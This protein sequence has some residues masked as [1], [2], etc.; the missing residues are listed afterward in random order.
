[1][2]AILNTTA[3]DPK[4]RFI[5]PTLMGLLCGAI[6]LLALLYHASA[7]SANILC[8]KPGGG[9]GCYASIT[10]ALGSAQADDT[11]RVAMGTY[12]ESL[13]ITQTVA[14]EG[15]WNLDFSQRN[16]DL[17]VTT[18]RPSDPS[19]A[20]IVIT[21]QFADW[22][23]VAP[24]IDGFTIT[25]A[26]SNNH[27]GGVRMT[28]SNAIIS[29]N[30]ITDNTAYLYGG[31]VWVQRGAPLF[32]T[33]H[34]ENNLVDGYGGGIE[35]ESTQATLTGNIITS[36]VVTAQV[37]YGGGIA[38]EGGGPV[39]LTGNTIASNVVTAT[40]GYGGGI[41]VQQGGPIALS[42]NTVN[43][44]SIVYPSSLH[45]P[46]KAGSPS[47]A[48]RGPSRTIGSLDPNGNAGGAGGGVSLQYV[49]AT[50]SSNII[51]DN[52][53]A[54]RYN[55]Y[56]GGT[57]IYSATV[58]LD[59]NTIQS[60]TSTL[61]ASG[62]A[63]GYGG[64]S[65]ALLGTTTF[66][67]DTVQNNNT[68]ANNVRG[69]GGGLFAEQAQVNLDAVRITSNHA[70]LEGGLAFLGALVD[71]SPA[72]TMTNSLVAN[73]SATTYGGVTADSVAPGT[74]A[75]DTVINNG[76]LGIYTESPLTITNSII[77]SHTLGIN[78]SH[79]ITETYND[80]YANT[81]N[82]Q[83]FTLDPTDLTVNPQLTSNYHLSA[84]SPVMDAGTRN[85]AP[86]DDIDGE[87]RPMKGTSGLYKVDIGADE[88]TGPAQTN[89]HL[90]T[91]PADF[92]LI[93]PGNPT[94]NPNSD[95]SNDWI[96]YSV[97]GGDVNGDNK[98]DLFAGA[99]NLSDDFDGG[100]ND[101]GRTFGL[102]GN[103]TR[104]LG[105]TDLLTTTP[106][107]EVRSWIHQQHTSQALAAA[108]LNGDG[109]SDLIIGS[110]GGD[111]NGTPVTGTV[112][113]F[114]G[115]PGLS[116]TRTLS[117]TMQANWRFKSGE[118]TQTFA[119]KNALAAGQ[120]N[121]TG[122]DDLAMGEAKATGPGNRTHAGAIYVFFGSNNLPP[123]WDLGTTPASL[124]IYGPANEA[125]LGKVA[126]GDV[127]GDGK[128]DLIARS[129]S[130]IYVFYGPLPSGVID[131]AT[132]PADA[133]ITNADDGWLAAGDVNGDGKADIV[134]S[135]P[136]EAD[137]VLGGNLPSTQTL[138]QAAWAT[139]TGVNA[140]SLW[141]ADWNADGK[142]E[143]LVGDPL[144]NRTFVIFGG[145][146]L[147][148]T[149]DIYERA[150]WIIY[151]ESL[152]DQFGHSLGSADL[153]GDGVTD[154]ILGSRIH[155][156]DDHPNH[157]AD[158][159]AVYVLYGT[160][161]QPGG[162][163]TPTPGTPSPTR[164]QGG[165]TLTTTPGGP[166]ATPGGPTL[167]TTPVI[168]NISFSDVPVGSTFYPYIHC[169]ACL[170]II[171][172]YPD[173]S[174]KPNNDVTRGQLAKIVSNSAGFS[175]NQTTR[176]FQDVAS[177]ST[178]FQYIGRLASRGY[179]SGY[180]CGAGEPCVPPD[181]LPYF[182]PNNNAT[183]GQI[184]K[185]VSNAAG[186]NDPP[187]NQIFQDVAPGST[188]YDYVQRLASRGYISGYR[189]GG[190]VPPGSE[191][192]IPPGNRPYFR[193][194]NNATRGQT[195][196]IVSNTFFP[197]CQAHGIVKPGG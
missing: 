38:V 96:G 191:P 121:G 73:N 72:Y 153:D 117:P 91:Q 168:C 92:T 7:A 122:P 60:N 187:G 9:D 34:I 44:N 140:G 145:I 21:G 10:A 180:P 176:T 151:G 177:G 55:G 61:D 119:G 166:T 20:V 136:T 110:Q 133:T 1:M 65:Y 143:V 120:L 5:V 25:G 115:G 157:F 105:V 102:Y 28:D 167:T 118:S 39:T 31:G 124:T 150:D 33:N 131:L 165:P 189:C 128:P 155:N 18:I 149:A 109:V 32:Q 58:A 68:N 156:V 158:A 50:L 146:S 183:R 52:I 154:L 89:R 197:D 126:I 193:P 49:T 137:V 24:T 103:G 139:F 64:G 148:G 171:S 101:S 107:L 40:F 2:L 164:T 16:P 173:G 195:S 67:G 185:I 113:V 190:G 14:L 51:L 63:Y 114:A 116:G 106:S 29:H 184:A 66:N 36:N 84:S 83:G 111:N 181:N 170:G 160:H 90:A 8:V 76:D 112:F 123:L 27:G 196:K 134:V 161:G 78:A 19:F 56:G 127:N 6:G 169:L 37:G 142:A 79:G 152:G 3:R 45:Q 162:T 47:V 43:D 41:D 30:V 186:F 62:G 178:F 70:Y 163:P 88:F 141:T 86:Q 69:Q 179:M 77:M 95:G 174:F 71:G 15:G 82:A 94:D 135:T 80:F 129:P 54:D 175:D 93:G 46:G 74:M 192:C 48:F 97:L 130:T 194:S 23:A 100:V 57:Y 132:T 75:N 12:T 85:G 172:G 42:G 17:F 35:L 147:Q 53:A 144:D 26:R 188:F 159:G 59:H 99:P 138:Q 98:A 104:R 108:D 87:P 11:I 182:R 4:R 22:S 81:T 125:Q 13:A